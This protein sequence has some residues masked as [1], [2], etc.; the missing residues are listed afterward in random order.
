MNCIKEHPQ[1]QTSPM[2]VFLPYKAKGS[3]RF[4][5]DVYDYNEYKGYKGFCLGKD[6]TS[7][8][9]HLKGVY[10]K[11]VTALVQDI[12]ERGNKRNLVLDFGAHIGWYSVIAALYGYHVAAIEGDRQNIEMLIKNATYNKLEKKLILN[13]TF[14]DELSPAVEL[15]TKQNIQLM[16]AD[17]HGYEYVAFEMCRNLFEQKRVNYAILKMSFTQDQAVSFIEDVIETGYSV[18]LI[19]PNTNDEYEANPLKYT[20][21]HCKL[22]KE[23]YTKA[24]KTMYQQYL[25]VKDKVWN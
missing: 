14:I 4:V 3:K 23:G 25:F 15:T 12:L 17:I 1:H 24:T 9:V 11:P 10:E 6:K 18:Y 2:K 16:K 5:M 21:T 13:H 7:E 22:D 8:H 19:P 20:Q